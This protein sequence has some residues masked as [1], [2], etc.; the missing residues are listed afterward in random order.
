VISG[1]PYF[2]Y[3]AFV[4]VGFGFAVLFSALGALFALLITNRLPQLFHGWFYAAR[5]SKVTNDG[6]FVSVEAHDKQYDAAKTKSFLESI[7]GT[8]VEVVQ[9]E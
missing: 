8:H 9:G 7:G 2:S 3:V 4:P 6:F 5:F 1:K